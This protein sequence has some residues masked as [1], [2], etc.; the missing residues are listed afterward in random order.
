MNRRQRR[1]GLCQECTDAIRAA[2]GAAGAQQLWVPLFKQHSKDPV[3]LQ[4]L[5]LLACWLSTAG[6]APHAPQ[7]EPAEARHVSPAAMQ[8]RKTSPK[9]LSASPTQHD[10]CQGAEGRKG[11][12]SVLAEGSQH[13]R[14]DAEGAYTRPCCFANYF[15][16]LEA[17]AL[18]PKSLGK[19]RLFDNV[20]SLAGGMSLDRN[21]EE[22]LQLQVAAM[23]VG[24]GA[25]ALPMW[26]EFLSRYFR[27][28]AWPLHP[29]ASHL[30]PH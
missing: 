8:S 12:S 27:Y 1:Y 14:A 19:L 21:A 11:T 22:A 20:Y 16:A 24:Y 29:V 10:A 26:E 3:K 7:K 13:Y 17:N 25:A 5:P 30:F 15:V 23:H 6:S 18:K 2:I 28:Q 9:K 4:W